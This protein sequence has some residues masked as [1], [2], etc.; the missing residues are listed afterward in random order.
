MRIHLPINPNL[1]RRLQVY[2]ILTTSRDIYQGELI[3]LLTFCA[4]VYVLR[5]VRLT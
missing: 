5:V 2:S 3:W 1:I 4:T